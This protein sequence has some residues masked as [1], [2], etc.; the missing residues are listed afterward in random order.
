M[1][2]ALL[3]P[4]HNRFLV[5]SETSRS[6]FYVLYDSSI[7]R[8]YAEWY[9]SGRSRLAAHLGQEQRHTLDDRVK[10]WIVGLV[11]ASHI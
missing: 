3:Q 4:I 5:L 8:N 11:L 10:L 9:L 2:L 7:V 6:V 1:K